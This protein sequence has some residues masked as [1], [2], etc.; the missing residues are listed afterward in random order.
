MRGIGLRRRAFACLRSVNS[1]LGLQDYDDV[2]GKR[3]KVL[4]HKVKS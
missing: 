1:V 4:L 2:C 3:M